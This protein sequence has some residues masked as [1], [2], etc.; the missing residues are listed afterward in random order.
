M[1]EAQWSSSDEAFQYGGRLLTD[2]EITL[3]ALRESDLS[4]LVAWWNSPEWAGLQQ[5]IVKPRPEAPIEE[6]LRNWSAN[7][8][9]GDTGFCI[10]S[11]E[12]GELLGHLTLHGA[13]LPERCASFAILIGPDH[14]GHGIGPKATLL[15]LSYGFRELGLNRIELR[16]WAFN[17]RAIRAYEKAGFVVEGRRRDAVFHDGRFHD[18]LIMSVLARDYFAA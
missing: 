9:L 12:G 17:T 10:V 6:M 8:P 3:R 4:T 1:S 13:S 15:A 18:E 11:N 5:R 14:V 7:K 2:G 16:A